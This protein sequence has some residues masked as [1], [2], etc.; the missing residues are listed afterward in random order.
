MKGRRAKATRYDI[1]QDEFEAIKIETAEKVKRLRAV[2]PKDERET[3]VRNYFTKQDE[4][5][6]FPEWP[7]HF[8]EMAL[9]KHKR[10]RERYRL[11]LFFVYNGLNPLT[12]RMWVV[13][14]DWKGRFIEEDYDR[15]AWSQLDSQVTEA[16]NGDI[17]KKMQGTMWDMINRRVE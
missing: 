4:F 6:S 7:K 13:M 1:D 12:A 3:R 14:N 17:Y 10:Y 2:V 9:M 5:W 8:Q 15:S 16:F 11:F